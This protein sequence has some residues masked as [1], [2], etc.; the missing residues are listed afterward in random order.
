M[1]K[2]SQ[3][4]QAVENILKQ[5]TAGYNIQRNAERNHDPNVAAKGNGWINITKGTLDYEA[6]AIG[7]KP[8]Q[9]TVEVK[10]E[11]QYAHNEGWKCEDG[12]EDAVNE[13]TTLLNSHPTF[14]GFVSMTTGFRIEY[15]LNEGIKPYHQAAIITFRAE[16]RA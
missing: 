16:V 5:N 6:F 11:I 12:L 2:F 3:I 8:W 15:E 7:S 13:I 9:V 1:I 14:E 4:T 10:V